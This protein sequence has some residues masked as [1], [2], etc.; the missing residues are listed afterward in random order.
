MLTSFHTYDLGRS[1][2]EFARSQAGHS[3]LNLMEFGER[4]SITGAHCGVSDLDMTCLLCRTESGP[5][6]SCHPAMIAPKAQ[7]GQ[8]LGLGACFGSLMSL[9]FPDSRY[10]Q[11]ACGVRRYVF[12]LQV[13]TQ[14]V[15]SL[16]RTVVMLNGLF[17]GV[18]VGRVGLG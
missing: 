16:H 15:P 10:F 13:P 17:G 14:R 9:Q 4:R 7:R 5:S 18:S 3:C 12:Q 1:G 2:G 11:I 6:D 8:L